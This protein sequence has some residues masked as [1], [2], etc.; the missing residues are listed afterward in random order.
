MQSFKINSS[1]QRARRRSDTDLFKQKKIMD[2]MMDHYTRLH[3]IMKEDFYKNYILSKEK[4]LL[5]SIPIDLMTADIHD[6]S[7]NYVVE[8]QVM[9]LKEFESA[10]IALYGIVNWWEMNYAVLCMEAPFLSKQIEVFF[11]S[12]LQEINAWYLIEKFLQQTPSN[13]KTEDWITYDHL[14]QSL[15]HAH[16]M[17]GEVFGFEQ[18]AYFIKLIHSVR[19]LYAYWNIPIHPADKLMSA[20]KIYEHASHCIIDLIYHFHFLQAE[21]VIN[22]EHNMQA[23][24]EAIALNAHKRDEFQDARASILMCIQDLVRFWFLEFKKAPSHVGYI[25]S[26]LNVQYEKVSNELFLKTNYWLFLREKRQ[27]DHRD[28]PVIALEEAML[29]DYGALKDK[30]NA[31]ASARIPLTRKI[32]EIAEHMHNIYLSSFEPSSISTPRRSQS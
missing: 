6:I 17:L 8:N 5:K 7:P 11:N 22:G 21:Q 29:N 18:S 27:K 10:R 13:A 20:L 16:H 4:I 1:I 24:K 12:I 9:S 19:R 2:V 30:I 28:M 14:L 15:A 25:Y 3:E 26:S 31:V 32:P 23:I